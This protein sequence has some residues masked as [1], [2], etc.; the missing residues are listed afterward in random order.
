MEQQRCLD[1]VTDQVSRVLLSE[2]VHRIYRKSFYP[3]KAKYKIYDA[4]RIQEKQST[5]PCHR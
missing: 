1:R 5:F 3:L 2:K 4:Y